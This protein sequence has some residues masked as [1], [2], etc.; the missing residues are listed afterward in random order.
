MRKQ[1]RRIIALLMAVLIAC[2]VL[3][4]PTMAEGEDV[5]TVTWSGTVQCGGNKV[6]G[7]SLQLYESE[8]E[9]FKADTATLIEGAVAETNEQGEFT[10]E[11]GVIADRY[12]FIV[13]RHQNYKTTE[14]WKL[15]NSGVTN[16]TIEV[17]VKKEQTDFKFQQDGPISV[18]GDSYNG[19]TAGGGQTT[20]DIVYSIT[21]EG[22]IATVDSFT[23]VVTRSEGKSGSVT[24]QAVRPGNDTYKDATASYTL[25]FRAKDETF[26][27]E[28]DITEQQKLAIDDTF[29]RKA[30]ADK[31]SGT[32]TYTS[33]DSTI[34]TVDEAGK[35]TAVAVE[36]GKES[37]TVTITATL[38]ADDDYSSDTLTYGLK[39]VKKEL[40]EENFD[41]SETK[42][43]QS[44]TV[45]TTDKEY[46]NA[47]DKD[48]LPTDIGQYTVTYTSSNDVAKVDSTGKVTKEKAGKAVISATI[49]SS[50]Y[51]TKTISYTIYFQ[52]N[53]NLQ[54]EN[55]KS[56]VPIVIDETNTDMT[57]VVSEWASNMG[58]VT[59]SVADADNDLVTID[60]NT[61]AVTANAVRAK[62]DGTTEEPT[63]V[64]VT[65]TFTPNADIY[66]LVKTSISYKLKISKKE[67]TT[68][69]F[70]QEKPDSI[71]ATTKDFANVLS[72]GESTGDYKYES[73]AH[74]I[75]EVGDDGKL[76]IHKA[77]TVTI[78]GYKEGDKNYKTSDSVSYTITIN[79][80]EQT[81]FGFTRTDSPIYVEAEVDSYDGNTAAGGQ[82][83]E[84][85]RYSII[86]GENIAKI[87][88]STGIVTR[89]GEAYG[90]VTVQATRPENDIYNK[91]TDTYQLVFRTTDV[92]FAWKTSDIPQP[93][94]L[95]K[96]YT[97]TA[98]ATYSQG[99][100]TY[101]SSDSTIAK[102]DE[103]TGEVTAVAV[104]SGNETSE[105]KITAT[106][107]ASGVYSKQSIEYTL[108]IAK[109]T[110]TPSDFAFKNSS[111][112]IEVEISQDSFSNPIEKN[113]SKK[114]VTYKSSDPDVATVDKNGKV[115][116]VQPGEVVI[117]ASVP[118][119][120]KYQ[121]AE[122][123]YTLIFKGK[124]GLGFG[125]NA[126]GKKLEIGQSLTQT[127]T[128]TRPR[129]GTITYSVANEDKDLVD[130][131]AKTGAVK[132]LKVR[133]KENESTV[134]VT[135]TFT[136]NETFKSSYSTETASYKLT[137]IKKTQAELNFKNQAPSEIKTTA[138]FC[139]EAWGGSTAN[140]IK[141]TSSDENI[142]SVDE[143][144]KLTIITSGTV[145]ITATRPGNEVYYDKENKYTVTILRDEQAPLVLSKGD[146]VDLCYGQ[147]MNNVVSGG[148]G[149]GAITYTSSKPEVV[150]VDVSGSIRAI[151]VSDEAVTITVTKAA[152]AKYNETK[153][154]YTV[155]TSYYEP[156]AGEAYKIT[157]QKA[158]AD[159]EWYV[160]NIAIEAQ[161]GYKVSYF[162]SLTGND[163]KDRLANVVGEDGIQTVRFYVE[164]LDD[165]GQVIGISDTVTY[166]LYKDTTLPDVTVKSDYA[167]K[168]AHN[169]NATVHLEVKDVTS[170]I[171]K[172]EYWIECDGVKYEV[173]AVQPEG[174]K[175]W[176]QDITVSAEKYNSDNVKVV[177]VA[178]DVAGRVSAEKSVALIF[179]TTAPKIDVHYTQDENCV[180]TVNGKGYFNTVRTAIVVITERTSHFNA[181]KATEGI[182][183]TATDFAGQ[184]VANAYQITDWKTVEA[185]TP[186]GAT[187]TA[188]I[189]FTADAN[190]TLDVSYVDEAG[191]RSLRTDY[192]HSVSPAQFTV[193]M[194]KPQG[195]L[196]V[197]TFGSWSQLLNTIG[198]RFFTNDKLAVSAE[199]SD[200][201]SGVESVEYY[202]TS[203]EDRLTLEELNQ[204][205]EWKVFAPFAI[206]GDQRATVYLKITDYAKNVT[207][208]CSDGMIYD[209][210]A[211]EITITT[212]YVE[213]G[214]YADDVTASVSVTDPVAGETYSG[215]KN[216]SYEILNMG[217]VTASGTLYAYD[218]MKDVVQSYSG[219][220]PV[221]KN[222]NSNNVV[223]RVK[224]V[225]NAG[226]EKVMTHTIAIDTTAPGISVS[227]DNN[228]GDGSLD[229]AV[230]YKDSRVATIRIYERNF[231][232]N[233][234][235]V[236]ITSTG[237][238]IP[239]VSAWTTSA[240][241]GNGD[242]NVHV[243]TITYSADGDYTF[244]I[245]CT[246]IAGN[247]NAAP[248]YGE[249]QAPTAFVIDMT[250]P[251]ISVSYDGPAAVNGN[252][253]NAARTATITIQE[254]N[255][256]ASRVV[257]RATASD[258]GSDIAAPVISNWVSAGDVNTATV[259]FENNALYDWNLEYTDKAGNEAQPLEKQ[260]FYVDNQAPVVTVRGLNNHS[261]HNEQENIGI[262]V[263]CVDN[264]GNLDSCVPVLT[265]I[266]KNG[267]SFAS[268]T[269][270]WTEVT[271]TNGK[272]YF[273]S[274][275][276]QDGIY[277]LSISAVDMAGNEYTE[278]NILDESG[279][280][281][282]QEATAGE[283]IFAF[284][285]NREGS[286]FWIEDADYTDEVLTH[287]YVQNVA[288]D[289]E[290]KEVDVDP[291]LSYKVS[292]NGK[293]L[294]EGTDYT[295]TSL[296][297]EKE[298][299][300]Y[301]FAVSKALFEAEGSYNIVVE[302]VDKTKTTAYSD[303]KNL[304]VSFVVDRTAPVVTLS[305]LEN[306]ASYRTDE[307][308]VYAIPTDDGG[309][310]KSI[311]V[312]VT[313]RN[314]N[315]VTD[316]NGQDISV[317]FSAK[318]EEL[319]TY[320]EENH[321]QIQ[322]TIPEGINQT[323]EIICSDYAVGEDM[324]A[325]V[326][327]QTFE[328]IT[329][330]PSAFVIFR[331][332]TGLFVGTIAGAVVLAAGV[333]VSIVF[334]RRKRLKK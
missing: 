62:E 142:A 321:G 277:R 159:G 279:N 236:D 128:I 132:A 232:A 274:N 30:K 202:K 333:S 60:P 140:A 31:S 212:P 248:D 284:S 138:D 17:E 136:P 112:R 207:Y 218:S 272:R 145:T 102:V 71:L 330:S 152:D 6:S 266:T 56:E 327:Y 183:V 130:I 288:K 3:P 194:T 243:A 273:I 129:V 156:V 28:T 154:S 172:V 151:G 19:N 240:G 108:T 246:D 78:T 177:A 322:F 175:E 79:K 127:A 276:E 66:Y 29:T 10:L 292:L 233:R 92:T 282:T 104:K 220:I 22:D 245:S 309:K 174:S 87:N 90:T 168:K 325:N 256:E 201:T 149:N 301:V 298:W 147:S 41:F 251:Q 7:A 9:V 192:N 101:K 244:G 188:M 329:V 98:G 63:T 196:S 186:D 222:N 65:A 170:G 315:P 61:G 316:A 237:G 324:T 8:D 280:E 216:V 300:E 285:V 241:S 122:I 58:T 94:E 163:W 254:H 38:A 223:I 109:K 323:V 314:G 231:D 53:A 217:E 20:A 219:S 262:T 119:S 144:G 26:R 91:A 51:S 46:T 81:D 146:E 75:A 184:N 93:L 226:N 126:D 124:S 114:T 99:A 164:K 185:D 252:Y 229:N 260:S 242:N 48:A 286:Y 11:Y 257:Y 249:S 70:A 139:N 160:S 176:K 191:N 95:D 141:Y 82:S 238:V 182:T 283:E 224:S 293:E 150:S 4:M 69:Q 267:N 208:I 195:T 49:T 80:A 230:Y 319:D 133:A 205:Q 39:I 57:V 36:E 299:Y 54:W 88:S 294:Q 179:D 16:I 198:F 158:I 103:N 281:V 271:I 227:Y 134:E 320:L 261:A 199:Y 312:T 203:D 148:S 85:V 107:A 239:T 308:V 14:P 113:V 121:A 290:I 296:G 181:A 12:Y 200:A 155:S 259:T 13:V 106:V 97:R 250:R 115:T 313:D 263:E 50:N 86:A 187:H 214:I 275:L 131:D 76:T 318:E 269:V 105:V 83:G 328:R 193:D 45:S 52:S 317:R 42:K 247:G 89:N 331:S 40:P 265:T 171:A 209:S 116:K 157:G 189:S 120:E 213:N 253:F 311:Q 43:N 67:Q 74:S 73:S 55:G 169:K 162:N 24:V 258:N 310:V 111:N 59:Y 197:D 302:S 178:T 1:K 268:D 303:V 326:S 167:D 334:A 123:S 278:M 33:S 161:P 210:A 332:N 84:A 287:Y 305:G 23:G 264:E 165:N 211:P 206:E 117:T 64:V 34:A 307:Q 21:S 304:A 173:T 44:H 289:I 72:G 166:T 234:V 25:V 225:D 68:P 18:D 47:I 228:S 235:Q 15:E 204:L 221:S 125:E 297:G 118:S 291:L 137:I 32:I 35:V 110:Q 153:T 255:F 215:L 96:T 143:K 135:A 37:S 100:I 180:Q 270:R 295:V 2:S 190:Y 27:W 77:G 306:S 5:S